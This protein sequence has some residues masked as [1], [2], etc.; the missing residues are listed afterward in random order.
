MFRADDYEKLGTLFLGRVLAEDGAPTDAPLLY[1]A[2]DLTTHAVCVGMTGSGKTGLCLALLEE[3]ALDGIP[4]LAI[5]PKGDLGN[6]LLTFPALRPDDFAPWIDPAEAARAGQAPAEYAKTIA[7][8]WRKGLADWGQAPSRIQALRDAADLAIYTPG[9]TAGRPLRLLRS[10]D[11]PPPALAADPEAVRERLQAAV[12][13]LLALLGLSADPVQSRESIL[14]QNIV[15]TAWNAGQS[16]DLAALIRAI[17]QPPFERVGVFD[18]ES[19]YPAKERTALAM[20]LNNL[21]ASP[22][23]GAWLEG[24]PLDVARLLYTPE[25][26]P[27]LCVLSIAHLSDGERMFFVTLLLSE[28]IAWMRAQS[29][30]QSLRALLYMDEI[31]GYFP[32]TA[33]PPSKPPMLT[34]LKQA[35]AYGVGVVLATQNPVDL[36]YKGLANTGT[37]FLGRLQTERD[38]LR[39]LEGLEGASSATGKAFDRGAVERTLAGL[40]SRKFLMHNVHDDAPTLFESRWA[41]SYLR[42]PLTREQIR[43]LTQ[44]ASAAAAAGGAPTAG[45]EP[46]AAA[47]AAVATGAASPPPAA[48]SGGPAPRPTLP[49]GIEERFGTPPAGGTSGGLVYEPLLFATAS[50]HYVHAPARLDA[51]QSLALVAPLADA[52]AEAPWENLRELPGKPPLAAAPEPGAAFAPL[53][54]LAQRPA[55]YAR[56]AKMLESRLFQAR[57]VTIYECK[58]LKAFSS[59]GEALGDFRARLRDRLHETRDLEVEKLRRKWAPKLAALEERQRR[60]QERA[61]RERDDYASKKLETAVSLGASVLGAL[62][63]RKLASATNVGRAASVARSAGRA[64]REREDIA[65][66]E[67]SAEAIAAQRKELEA[68]FQAELDAL[69]GGGSDVERLE[70]AAISVA[71]RKGDL[72]VD[73]LALLWLPRAR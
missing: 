8:R 24:E 45:A 68:Q 51:W 50:A 20:S 36:D 29:G 48:A 1:D 57:P 63:G 60:A 32:P 23:F 47:T 17:Q 11:A 67:E 35:R 34:L 55:S 28:L 18:L 30:T 58:A 52:S 26:K 65:R 19:F 7:E 10:F 39:V 25:G 49:A 31:F 42:G 44:S 16:L 66:A 41:L 62:F 40:G 5:D 21:L 15:A 64:A 59:P 37:W 14:L 43:R 70:I 46:R 72:S 71:P 56:W 61:E 2:K 38:K 73:S 22:S 3:A 69:R 54:A 53:P 13:S 33:N 9:S 4:A 12:S 6:L 27:R